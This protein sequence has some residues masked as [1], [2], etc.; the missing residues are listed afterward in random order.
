MRLESG[1]RLESRTTLGTGSF[2]KLLNRLIKL[3][4]LDRGVLLR[5]KGV[6][7][8]TLAVLALAPICVARGTDK[9]MLSGAEDPSQP[10]T[11]ET[12]SGTQ[13]ALPGN[14][15]SYQGLVVRHIEFRGIRPDNQERLR[16]LIAQKTGQPFDREL[17]RQSIQSLWASRRFEDIQVAAERTSDNQVDLIFITTAS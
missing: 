4:G 16:Q 8:T 1:L 11:P 2:I 7:L 3:A 5:L 14:A 15:S 9:G 10:Q 13:P 17:I 6:L 12:G